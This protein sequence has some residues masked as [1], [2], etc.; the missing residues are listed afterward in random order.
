MSGLLRTGNSGLGPEI[1]FEAEGEE[2]ET[3]LQ[4]CPVTVSN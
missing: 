1:I 4:R 3:P 2:T